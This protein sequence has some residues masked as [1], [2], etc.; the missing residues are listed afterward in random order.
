M[1]ESLR[2]KYRDV[3]EASTK[4]A[5]LRGNQEFGIGL[6]RLADIENKGTVP[7]VYRMYSLAAIYGLSF[8]KILNW[9]G[10]DID[11]LPTDSA[12]ISLPHTRPIDFETSPDAEFPVPTE[13]QHHWD[14]SKTSFLSRQVQRWG[15]LPIALLGKLDNRYRYGLIGENDWS[16]YPILAPGSFVQIDESKRRIASAGWSH[17]F[18]RPIYFL[19]HRKG[20]RCGWC[21]QKDGFLLLQTHSGSQV[22]SEIYRYPGE[23]DIVGQVIGVAMRLNLGKRPHTRS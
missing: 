4:I 5:K 18:E 12:C 6:S 20:Y 7:S 21:T 11:A 15:K 13:V 16:M 8:S 1:R 10:V 2:L 22:P 14:I 17:E 19:E 23:A 9:Y 3:E